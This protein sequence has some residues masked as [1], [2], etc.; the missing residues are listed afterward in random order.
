MLYFRQI[1]IMAVSLYTVRVVLATLGAEDYGIYNVVAGV[2]VLFSFVN[3]AMAAS[4]QRFLNYNLGEKKLNKVREIYSA[5]ILMHFGISCVFVL[6]AESFG[7]YF[8]SFK[9]NI[10][11]ARHNAMLIVYQCTIVT[12][13]FSILRVPYNAIIIAYENMSFFAWIG[14]LE[15]VMKLLIVF[16]LGFCSFDKLVFYAF[17]LTVVS[18][19]ILCVNKLYCN[20]KFPTARF[21]KKID[22]NSAK[23]LVSFSGWSLFGSAI[24]VC[25]TQ[26]MNVILNIF[27]NVTVNT[28]MGIANQVNA[29]VYSFVSNFQT[30]FNPQIVKLYAENNR[31]YFEKLLYR[32]SKFSCFLLYFICLPL[33]VNI[34][35][36][37]SVWLKNV[38]EYACS[39]VR[40][41]LI[42]SMVDVFNNP[43]YTAIQATGRVKNYNILVSLFKIIPLPVTVISLYMGYAPTCVIFIQI[44]ADIFIN[45]W[46][47]L[48][49]HRHKLLCWKDF[50]LKVL[51]RCFFVIVPSLSV[52]WIIATVVGRY[53]FFVTCIVGALC[54]S[55]AIFLFG[56]DNTE[57]KF[58]VKKLHIPTRR[59]A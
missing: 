44:I 13:V 7:L 55:F 43:L 32:A 25:N 12:T 26:G 5:S 1:L 11:L 40:L 10:P 38:P 20:I 8:V 41:I 50:I 33:Y 46:R 24:A 54:T 58:V 6:L 21:T 2:V 16:L 36:V 29:A 35:F 56:F 48:F 27:T 53:R 22:R 30:A 15:T 31:V 23:E 57:R 42:L 17:L 49:C 37:L 19:V 59:F 51:W 9:L 39:F 14:I 34:E 18:G 52:V 47:L 28:A 3:T 4:T 45:A